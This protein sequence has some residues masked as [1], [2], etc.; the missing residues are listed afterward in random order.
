MR[1][2]VYGVATGSRQPPGG[3][4]LAASAGPHVPGS[5]SYTGGGAFSTGSTMRHA[6]ST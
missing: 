6:S 2:Q 5:Y 3:D 4:T 1:G